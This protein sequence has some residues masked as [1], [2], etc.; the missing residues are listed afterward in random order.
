MYPILFH[1]D[2]STEIGF[3][4]VYRCLAVAQALRWE[5]G[6]ST[7]LAMADGPPGFAAV[8]ESGFTLFAWNRQSFADRESWLQRVVEEEGVKALVFDLREGLNPD[9]FQILRRRGCLLVSI[10]DLTGNRLFMDI[11]FNPPVFDQDEMSWEGFEGQRFSGWEWVVLRGQ[12][13]FPENKKENRP[14]RILVT[15]G[16]SDP[17]GLTEMAVTALCLAGSGFQADIVLGPGFQRQ[18]EIQRLLGQACFLHQ[19]HNHVAEMAGVMAIA[20]L[21]VAS[22]GM[23]A[24]ELAA[25]GVPAIYLCLSPIH[26]RRAQGFALHG[27]ARNL[28]LYTQV[29]LEDLA[30]EI[31]KL[32]IDKGK[33]Q[34]M[35]QAACQKDLRHGARRVADRI[36]KAI[37]ETRNSS[38]SV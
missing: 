30:L 28:G 9:F 37:R 34:D 6:I 20:D 38:L 12:F 29:V 14:P 7:A 5:H 16:G 24:Y 33:R 31:H 35:S 26:Q 3:G 19:I 10:D 2:A 36:V 23:T 15:M 11:V 18:E 32:L 4:H 22:F 1:C 27:M 8:R 13:L 21:A 25:M 17:A